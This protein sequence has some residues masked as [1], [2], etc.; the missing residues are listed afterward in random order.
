MHFSGKVRHME[1]QLSEYLFIARTL[2]RSNRNIEMISG[3][4]ICLIFLEYKDEAY[5]LKSSPRGAGMAPIS[6]TIQ[7]IK[8]TLK[9]KEQ[10]VEKKIPW[11]TNRIPPLSLTV[12]RASYN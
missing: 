11:L 4:Q 1:F 2:L 10:K 5:P 3:I 8:Q 12:L 6:T 7:E 9:D